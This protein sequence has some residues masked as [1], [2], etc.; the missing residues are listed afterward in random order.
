MEEDLSLCVQ[1]LRKVLTTYAAGEGGQSC[2]D[3]RMWHLVAI[4]ALHTH[5]VKS[6]E[7]LSQ[8]EGLCTCGDRLRP[9][10]SHC[11]YGFRATHSVHFLPQVR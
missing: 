6:R 8:G 5:G 11:S 3:L 9:L 2:L 1:T 4:V 10:P 7:F